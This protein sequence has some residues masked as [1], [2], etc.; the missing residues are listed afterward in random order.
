MRKVLMVFVLLLFS[1]GTLFAAEPAK[2]Q[3]K[4]PE[5]EKK[6]EYQQ[7]ATKANMPQKM[8][9]MQKMQKKMDMKGHAKKMKQMKAAAQK[10]KQQIEN[11]TKEVKKLSGLNKHLVIGNLKLWGYL[12]MRYLDNLQGTFS[13]LSLEEITFNMAYHPS[14]DITAWINMWWHPNQ[15]KLVRT[16]EGVNSNGVVEGVYPGEMIGY[17]WFERAQAELKLPSLGSFAQKIRL[18]KW[19]RASF[20]IAPGYPNRKISDYSLVAEAF[21]HDRVTGLEY[22]TTFKKKLSLNFS[23]FNG[24]NI[25]DRNIG[26]VDP[27]GN[28]QTVTIVADR[29]QLTTL[30][31]DM[32]KGVSGKLGFIAL[33]DNYKKA[34]HGNGNFLSFDVFGEIG[35]KLSAGDFKKLDGYYG[36]NSVNHGN[37]N[38]YR[39]G[40]DARLVLG[41]FSSDT[42]LFKGWT[43]NIQTVGFQILGVYK[44]LP[45]K[46]DLLAR[47]GI[48]NNVNVE[49]VESLPATWDK[50]QIQL[51]AKYYL[52]TWAWIQAEYDFNF[53]RTIAHSLNPITD[54]Q[55]NKVKNDKF[56]IE[57]VF[58]YM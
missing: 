1:M 28:S 15:I 22:L 17:S 58:F 11:L 2:T 55:W 38:K 31:T 43:S 40:A 24:E 25:G 32:N 21:T 16:F 7:P 54:F 36:A 14:K 3:E 49:H 13:S 8:Q 50:S 27:T 26:T 18:G 53:E 52:A 51:S 20:G 37:V 34:Y 45:K 39:A 23:V 44:L 5:K 42:E 29:E 19:Y 56:F 33:G 12:R 6:V 10:Q 9:K 4:Q 48:L 57:F 30:D 35:N 41:K 46:V 47:Y